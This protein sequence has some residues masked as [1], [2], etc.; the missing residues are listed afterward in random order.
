M[1]SRL[2]FLLSQFMDV[3]SLLMITKQKRQSSIRLLALVLNE[4]PDSFHMQPASLQCE[5]QVGLY[6]SP[7]LMEIFRAST[8]SS[9]EMMLILLLTLVLISLCDCTYAH[10]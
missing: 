4:A 3:R 8:K 6:F 5:S 2:T 7:S 1:A 9:S 10:S